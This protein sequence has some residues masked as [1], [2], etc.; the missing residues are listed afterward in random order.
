MACV[1]G[2]VMW[3][4]TDG[5]TD[6]VLRLAPLVGLSFGIVFPITMAW[7][8]RRSEAKGSEDE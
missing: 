1:W 7:L 6:Q 8:E 3:F 4:I 5:D 2:A